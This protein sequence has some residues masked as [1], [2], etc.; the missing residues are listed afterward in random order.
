MGKKSETSK[1]GVALLVVLF[2]VMAITIMSLGFLA[3]SDVELACSQNMI[4]R[5]QMD[6]LAESGLGHAKG[7]ILNPQ[8]IAS[9]Y[10]TGASGQQLVAG[11]DDYYDVS[12]VKLGECNYQIASTAY[13]QKGGEQIG[14]SS[15]TAE[16]RLDPCI[17]FWCANATTISAQIVIQGD[18][19]CGNGL[20]NQGII[21]GDVYSTGTI[22]NTSPGQIM[23]HTYGNVIAAPVGWPGLSI[24]DFSSY[25]YIEHSMYSVQQIAAGKYADLNLGPSVDNPAGIYYCDGDLELEG[26]VTV[27]GT[28]VVKN[29]LEITGSGNTV[30][31]IKNFPAIITGAEIGINKNTL[32]GLTVEDLFR[33]EAGYVSR[34]PRKMRSCIY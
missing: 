26:N 13:R 17:V 29:T 22:T 19:Y 20:G 27:Q 4:L 1:K 15:L 21:G 9:E 28:L 34:L 12:V 2:I 16:L 32:P 24:V 18:V 14:R 23:G 11:S 25:Y 7:L 3:R 8:D 31:A 30:T 5:T 10:W 6:Y 33:L